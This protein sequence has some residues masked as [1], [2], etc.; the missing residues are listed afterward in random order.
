VKRAPLKIILRCDPRCIQQIN[1]A[2]HNVE[3]KIT[4][5]LT[6]F[7]KMVV[8]EDENDTMDNLIDYVFCE[9]RTDLED[10]LVQDTRGDYY[11]IDRDTVIENIL[12]HLHS[13]MLEVTNTAYGAVPRDCHHEMREYRFT[14]MQ[15]PG[16]FLI[17]RTA[18]TSLRVRQFGTNVKEL[19]V[20]PSFLRVSNLPILTRPA[21]EVVVQPM[22]SINFGATDKPTHASLADQYRAQGEDDLLDH[23]REGFYTAY[24]DVSLFKF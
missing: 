9:L 12:Q 13:F 3:F 24:R 17:E 10:C 14:Q 23:I 15:G 20:Q 18:C 6:D 22:V 4:D 19:T 21:D 2:Q 8:G 11:A 7:F 1:S 16:A 5:L